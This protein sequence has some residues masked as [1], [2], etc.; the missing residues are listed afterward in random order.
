MLKPRGYFGD[1]VYVCQGFGEHWVNEILCFLF[2]LY[3]N[4]PEIY[5]KRGSCAQKISVL[6]FGFW[7]DNLAEKFFCG[8]RLL[9][10]PL[11]QVLHREHG[12][13]VRKKQEVAHNQCY[14]ITVLTEAEITAISLENTQEFSYRF[15]WKPLRTLFTLMSRILWTFLQ[16]YDNSRDSWEFEL[17]PNRRARIFYFIFILVGVGLSHYTS[18][19][20][21]LL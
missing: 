2:L 9:Y 17:L 3:I 18:L 4:T 6:W 12:R 16:W 13:D 15:C 1:I 21:S 20:P 7:C 19:F 14:C 10:A 8:E 11:L 5:D